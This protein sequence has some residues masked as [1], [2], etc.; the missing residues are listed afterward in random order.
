MKVGDRFVTYIL[1]DYNSFSK[2]NLL[3]GDSAT[4]KSCLAEICSEAERGVA[5]TLVSEGYNFHV[6][7]ADTSRLCNI[8]IQGWSDTLIIMDEESPFLS[9]KGD[10]IQSVIN[11]TSNKFLI[12]SRDKKL[13]FLSIP[14]YAIWSIHNSGRYNNIKMRYKDIP[15]LSFQVFVNTVLLEDSKSSYFLFRDYFNGLNIC[16]AKGKDNVYNELKRILLENK[17]QSILVVIDSCAYGLA[18]EGLKHLLDL[19]ANVY[20][21]SWKC[22]EEYILRSSNFNGVELNPDMQESDYEV[23]L[24]SLIT[25]N[26]QKV[27]KCITL[28]NKCSECKNY[29]DC[30][31]KVHVSRRENYIHSELKYLS[32]EKEEKMDNSSEVHGFLS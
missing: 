16:S 15:N 11:S 26:K 9:Q 29:K 3:Q 31:Y 5:G 7:T 18:Y 28:K 27:S 25:Y 13:N 2:V 12:I 23:L 21:L 22:Y 1:E 8:D 20:L 4:G 30:M 19:N 32:T 6:I 10:I 14:I 24:G 17:D